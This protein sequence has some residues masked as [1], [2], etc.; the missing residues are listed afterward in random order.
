[1]LKVDE[2][3]RAALR[4][5]R[6]ADSSLKPMNSIFKHYIE[7]F[8]QTFD[9]MS[10][11]AEQVQNFENWLF[12]E[13]KLSSS[14]VSRIM[15][16]F[17][18]IL[19]KCQKL[20]LL[21]RVPEFPRIV[22]DSNR[23]RFLSPDEARLILDLLQEMSPL[24][25]DIVLLTLNTG[26]RLGEVVSLK[27]ENVDPVNRI[28]I[29]LKTK[30]GKKRVIPLNDEALAVC[31]KYCRRANEYLF[32]SP[33]KKGMHIQK[34]SHLFIK[35]LKKT[36]INKGY[37]DRHRICFHS[38]RHTFASWLVQ[39]GVRLEIVSDLLGHSSVVTSQRYAHL[40]PDAGR[41]AVAKLPSLT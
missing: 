18:A 19:G 24:W 33:V 21:D 31:R 6:Y 40:A 4:Y 10:I 20:Q 13:R 35:A 41:A 16:I 30:N 17:Q 1:M 15:K 39:E 3:Y 2:A 14:Y 38:L 26:M 28:I 25:H 11:T 29:L 37:S 12:D 22:T 34:S 32:E 23:T 7:E 5:A 9:L 8:W 27:G 36:T